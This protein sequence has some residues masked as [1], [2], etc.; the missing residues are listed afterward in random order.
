MPETALRD[1]DACTLS[2]PDRASDLISERVK[3]GLS[4]AKA[5][6]KKLGSRPG[7]RPKSDKLAPNILKA[8]GEGRSIC[9]IAR[10]FRFRKNTVLIVKPHKQAG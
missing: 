1:L 7:Q 5:R 4:A 9:W 10:D 6:D 3:S 8:A 2:F